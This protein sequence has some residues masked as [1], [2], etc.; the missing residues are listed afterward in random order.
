[1]RLKSLLNSK[2]SDITPQKERIN[3]FTTDKWQN[4]EPMDKSAQNL[5]PSGSAERAYSS[6]MNI[7]SVCFNPKTKDVEIW[8]IPGN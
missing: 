8:V 4:P 3:I 5:S 2:S 7:V 6:S 1:M